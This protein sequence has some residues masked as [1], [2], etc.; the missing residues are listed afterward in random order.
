MAVSV[1]KWAGRVAALCAGCFLASGAALAEPY[2][3]VRTGLT[4]AACHINRTGGGSRTA[5][6]VGYGAQQLP[7]K[8]AS[9]SSAL[10]DGAIGERIRIGADL[11]AA[12][13]GR[14]PRDAPYVGDFRVSEVNLY[15]GTELLPDRLTLYLDERV[16]PGGALTREAFALIRPGPTGLYVKAGKFFLPFGFRLLDDEAA[17][18]RPT[19]FSFN[20]SDTGLELGLDAE[21]WS[22]VL[23]VSNGTA[24][25]P[26]SDN[27][28][29]V[30]FIGG[31]VR[32]HWRAGISVSSNDLPGPR[33]KS[34]GGAFTGV[35]FGPVVLLA[36]ADALRTNDA[37]GP[38][39]DGRAGHAELDL[40]LAEGL[41]LR[42]WAGRFDPDRDAGS[43]A[44]RQAGMGVEWTLL[45]GWQIRWM[46]RGREGP[47]GIPGSRDDEAI[48]EVHLYF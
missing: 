40:A 32:P 23:A 26:E 34:L 24:G 11:R 13:L 6:G 2:L 33:R 25:G 39:V 48:V 3:A 29:Q 22:G 7:W 46:F 15:V 21:G 16:G 36:E 47:A 4:C 30:S 41:S 19:G 9:G 1:K 18:R 44:L 31:H 17:T 37:T 28:K 42:L 12:Y 35:R 5:Y 43:D 10:F 27:G 20:S 8:K 38:A 14:L 45:P